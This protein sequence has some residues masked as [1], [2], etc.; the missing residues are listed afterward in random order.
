MQ[1]LYRDCPVSIVSAT[2]VLINMSVI[3][4]VSNTFMDELLKYL[5]SILL[6]RENALLHSH[7]EAQKLIRKLGLNYELIHSCPSG[8]VLYRGEYVDL[9]VCPKAS[10]GKSRY[11]AG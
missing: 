9:N 3:H 7:Y 6:S 1:S 5:S 2:I 11:I 8:C 10:C 4:G